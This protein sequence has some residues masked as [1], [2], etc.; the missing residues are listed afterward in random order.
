M[1]E[2][3]GWK[4]SNDGSLSTAGSNPNRTFELMGA[5]PKRWRVWVN[6]I[7]HI[8]KQS[9]ARCCHSG[10]VRTY[11]TAVYASDWD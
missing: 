4:Q 1:R 6:D 8:D 9:K 10:I 5:E 3:I 7:R 2:Q 11:S